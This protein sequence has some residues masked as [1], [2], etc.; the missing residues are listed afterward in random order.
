MGTVVCRRVAL[1]RFLSTCP[2]ATLGLYAELLTPAL[3]YFL[4]GSHSTHMHIHT[5]TQS[6]HRHIQSCARV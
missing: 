3:A 6:R 1:Q 4:P 2:M 5:R